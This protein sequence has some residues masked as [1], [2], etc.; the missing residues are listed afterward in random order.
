MFDYEKPHSPADVLRLIRLF[1]LKHFREAVY[2][3]FLEIGK[4]HPYETSRYI[5]KPS[6]LPKHYILGER[7]WFDGDVSV[8]FEGRAFPAPTGFDEYLK[9]RDKET[10]KTN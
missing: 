2:N 3:Y 6:A 10:K 9:N 8:E 1:F 7:S 5:G 4:K